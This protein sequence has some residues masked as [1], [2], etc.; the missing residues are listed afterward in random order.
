ML[1]TYTGRVLNGNPV[2][3]EG[4]VLPENASFIITI[5]DG[6]PS[7]KA[8]T[9]AQEQNEALKRLAAELKAIDDEPFDREFDE[10]AKHRFNIARD[11][12]V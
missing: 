11:L 1:S 3:S 6:F 4:V 7:A 2:L 10:M 8:K 5:L 12:D 9:K